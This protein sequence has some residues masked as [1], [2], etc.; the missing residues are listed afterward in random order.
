[1]HVSSLDQFCAP[2]VE[3]QAISNRE[4]L[5]CVN[6][7]PLGHFCFQPVRDLLRI[8]TDGCADT[9]RRKRS[10]GRHFINLLSGNPQQFSELTRF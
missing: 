10:F 3:L 5:L 9:K 4:P 2:S 8:K 1:M 7:D 6:R